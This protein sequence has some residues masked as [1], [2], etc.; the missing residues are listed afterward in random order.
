MRILVIDDHGL[1]RAGLALLLQQLQS[2][3]VVI[4]AESCEQALTL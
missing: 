4:E 1:F 3:V 2:N